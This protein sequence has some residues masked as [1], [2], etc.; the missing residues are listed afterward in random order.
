TKRKT[1]NVQV[2]KN[3]GK[4][5]Y[6]ID[7][8]D[9]VDLKRCVELAEEALEKGNA[10]FGSLLLSSDGEVLFEDHN[11][12]AGGDDTR[13]PDFEIARRAASN[14][15]EEE[16]HPAPVDTPAEH[17][18]LCAPARGLAPL[19]RTVYASSREQ[20]RH[21]HAALGVEAGNLRRHSIPEVIRDVEVD[22]P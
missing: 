10:P 3:L 5:E 19:G 22:G 13:R 16:R 12:N 7:E 6:M 15:S 17:G 20:L 8:T 2:D 4:G 9:R 1:I 18:S 21:G 14:R 11:R